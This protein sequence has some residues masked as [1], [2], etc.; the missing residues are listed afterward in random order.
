M[1]GPISLPIVV[2]GQ[3][4]DQQATLNSSYR[5]AKNKVSSLYKKIKTSFLFLNLI[6]ISRFFTKYCVIQYF[7]CKYC[8]Q[9]TVCV[10]N[11][12]L[13]EYFYNIKHS[14]N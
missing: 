4:K 12:Y 11:Y 14:T 3:T 5:C 2:P 13:Q 6:G 7:T 1:V 8:K 9:A 10:K